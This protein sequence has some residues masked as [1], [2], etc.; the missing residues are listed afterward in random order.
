M[1]S[2]L[3]SKCF[4]HSSYFVIDLPI[5]KS[6]NYWSC[7]ILKCTSIP[8]D[9]YWNH[10][11]YLSIHPYTWNNSKIDKLSLIKSDIENFLK[12]DHTISGSVWIGQLV[13]YA[14]AYS[15]FIHTTNTA[16][17]NTEVSCLFVVAC[18]WF[19][20]SGERYWKCIFLIIIVALFIMEHQ[21]LVFM[22]WKPG[23]I[24]RVNMP[25]LLCYVCTYPYLLN[26]KNHWNID[27]SVLLPLQE[28]LLTCCRFP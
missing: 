14:H 2:Y 26:F 17:L 20:K 10:T 4:M 22:N 11:I 9:T 13:C 27:F 8:M 15:W 1:L 7:S 21:K 24:N 19:V 12:I 5:Y 18:L 16:L 25:E 23:D 3:Y 6:Q 28:E